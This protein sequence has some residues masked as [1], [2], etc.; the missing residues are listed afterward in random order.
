[1]NTDKKRQ[2]RRSTSVREVSLA[3][4]LRIGH[5]RAFSNSHSVSP[6]LISWVDF[7][8]GRWDRLPASDLLDKNGKV[9]Y[10]TRFEVAGRLKIPYSPFTIGVRDKHRRRTR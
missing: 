8:W 3:G 2:P 4:G 5:F 1:M 9:R 6:S 10:G 7:T